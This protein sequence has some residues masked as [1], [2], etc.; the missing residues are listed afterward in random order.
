[1]SPRWGSTPR[2][3][4]RLIVGRNSFIH[5]QNLDRTRAL[6]KIARLSVVEKNNNSV[7]FSSYLRAN[8]TAQAPITKWA[9]V[10]KKKQNTKTRQIQTNTTIIFQMVLGLWHWKARQQHFVPFNFLCAQRDIRVLIL[11]RLWSAC[12]GR[13]LRPATWPVKSDAV[14]NAMGHVSLF[15]RCSFEIQISQ[16]RFLHI[17]SPRLQ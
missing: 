10:K 16:S 2:R 17:C 1:M 3:T 15:S 6:Y 14:S 5:S 13:Q 9:G 12:Y 11:N 7:L 4:D 8:L